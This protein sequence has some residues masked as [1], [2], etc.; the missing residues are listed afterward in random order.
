MEQ[1]RSVLL[2]IIECIGWIGSGAIVVLGIIFVRDVTQT[3]P[4]LRRNFPILGRMRYFLEEQGVYFR[5]YFFAHDRQELPFNRTT[6]NW[7]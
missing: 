4:A 6:R 3:R 5:Q 2:F 7:V 1:T